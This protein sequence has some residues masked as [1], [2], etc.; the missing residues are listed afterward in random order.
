M[1]KIRSWPAAPW[2][3]KNTYKQPVRMTFEV[4]F[5]AI[6]P[7]KRNFD[8]REAHR[9]AVEGLIELAPV[10]A[11]AIL[12]VM[13]AYGKDEATMSAAVV[14]LSLVSKDIRKIAG[15]EKLVPTSEVKND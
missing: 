12:G 4:G 14:A 10:M 2:V 5:S 3:V 1:S 9:S 11:E 15:P 13:D 6:V 7:G 8:E